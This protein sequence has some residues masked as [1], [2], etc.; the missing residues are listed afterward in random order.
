VNDAWKIS[1]LEN[2]AS[3]LVRVYNRYGGLVFSQTGYASPWDGHHRGMIVPSGT[4]YY[5]LIAKNGSQ[6]VNGSLT[7]IY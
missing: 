6:T 3:V 2:D 7:V 1:G 5:V 4:Y